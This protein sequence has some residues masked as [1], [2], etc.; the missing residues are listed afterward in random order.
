MFDTHIHTNFSTDSKLDIKEAYKSAKE[1]GISLIITEHLDSDYVD[2]NKFTFNQ[3]EYFKT[4][5]NLRSNDLLLGIELGMNPDFYKI[6]KEFI[7][8]YPFDY[9]LGSVHAINGYDLYFKDIYEKY[10]KKT[11]INLYLEYIIKCI[12]THPYINSLGHIDYITRYSLYEDKEMYYEDYKEGIDEL[13]KEII[14]RDIALEINTRRFNEEKAV[15]SYIEILKAYEA[16]GGEFV[17]IGSD[18]HKK[19]NIGKYLN[20]A[21]EIS[22]DLNLRP[23]YFKE[24]KMEYVR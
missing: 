8:G 16:L 15:K 23:V 4:F 13:L 5:G 21:Y 18:S 11:C 14:N 19:E 1:Q 10:D 22:K 6:N 3:R 24:G 17:T 20:K 12:K 7:E 2:K 9:I